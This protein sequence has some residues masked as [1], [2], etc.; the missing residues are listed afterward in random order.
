MNEFIFCFRDAILDFSVCSHPTVMKDLCAECGQDLREINQR[1][2]TAAV[3]MIHNIPELMVSL[4]VSK[5][6]Q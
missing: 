4:E 6:I 1:T 3:A 2:Q 5:S